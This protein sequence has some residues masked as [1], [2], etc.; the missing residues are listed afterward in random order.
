[1][2]ALYERMSALIWV[3]F[4]LCMAALLGGTAF[5]ALRALGTW[6]AVRSGLVDGF[7]ALERTLTA[8]ETTANRAAGL[9]ARG[10]QAVDAVESLRVSLAQARVLVAAAQE[11]QS[12]VLDVRAAVVPSK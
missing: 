1:M 4:G 5:V 12:L 7:A 2:S 3:G 9:A 11:A 8:A 6:R 10:E